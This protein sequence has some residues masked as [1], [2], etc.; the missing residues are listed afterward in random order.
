[1]YA[2]RIK[3]LDGADDDDVVIQVAHD[4]EF[5]LLPAEDALF[6]Q[7]LTD[8][9]KIDTT[10]QNFSHLLAVVGDTA[11]RTAQRKARTNDTGESYLG[12]EGKPVA[13]VRRE[14]R[15]R[16]IEP[17]AVHRV[18]EE[19]AI[20]GLLDGFQLRAD[21]LNPKPLQYSG[22]G[23]I[24]RKIECSLATHGRQDREHAGRARSLQHLRLDAQDLF[25]V[26]W[27]Q[28]LDV[29]SVG[30]L[31]VGHDR[32]RVR[33]H[34]HDFITLGLQRLAR[35]GSGVVKLGRLANHDR[36]RP[37]HENLC[38]VIPAWHSSCSFVT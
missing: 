3:V 12:C 1:M 29:S 32:C 16:H 18:L 13:N 31:R 22:V 24:D 11:A 37:D 15:P 21:Q 8:G 26:S 9:R 35:L 10:R 14:L 5:V 4:F 23:E 17:D 33:I 6:N 25:D 27:S 30:D 7:A 20:F 28:R 36:A 19:E 38:D 34:Q 2:H